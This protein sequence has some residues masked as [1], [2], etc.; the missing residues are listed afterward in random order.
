MK[1]IWLA[2]FF[3][4]LLFALLFS[5]QYGFLQ[6]QPSVPTDLPPP[7]AAHVAGRNSWKNIFQNGT[8][9][10]VSHATLAKVENGFVLRETLSLRLNTMGMI[11]NVSLDTSAKLQP[12]FSLS[13]FDFE[14]NSGRFRFTA[15]G[16]V[17]G[18]ALTIMTRSAGAT[19]K[20]HIP[21]DRKIYLSAG[22]IDALSAAAPAQARSISVAVFDPATLTQQQ[23]VVNR[24]GEEKIQIMGMARK[25]SKIS[26]TYKG[27]TQ[28]AWVAESGEILKEQGLLGI[29]LEKTS[30]EDALYGLAVQPG[31]DLTRVAS[32]AAN[33]RIETPETLDALQVKI[34]GMPL[35]GLNV[36]G[37]RQHLAGDTLRVTKESLLSLPDRLSADVVRERYADMLTPSIFIQSDHP[38]IRELAASITRTGRTLLEQVNLLLAWI[39]RNIEKKPV[40]SLPDALSTLENRM[41]DCN[42]HA[43]LFAALARALA[44]PCKVE[45]GLVYLDG[46]FYYH[47]WNAVYLGRWIT[48]DALFSQFPADVTHLRFSSGAHQID[49]SIMAIMGK[50]ELEVLQ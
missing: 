17:A 34:S 10:G 1:Y 44:I 6:P 27:I 48:V 13:S 35:D 36:A 38:R 8:K 20:D 14:I 45:A 4:G 22:I 23:V 26:L 47:A 12:D 50:I 33:I 18:D 28:Y 7:A 49:P 11:Q 9:I 40:L 19:R 30:R 37:G 16:T 42:E 41:G 43:M 5:R 46:R 29:T 2:V 25:T 24:L 32:V 31:Q 3:S 15:T 39:D 21:L